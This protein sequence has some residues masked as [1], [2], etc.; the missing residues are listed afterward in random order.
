MERA[1]QLAWNRS[2]IE[3]RHLHLTS[4][5]AKNFQTFAGRV[6]FRPPLK[7]RHKQSI[8]V[9]SQGQSSLWAY[10][11]SGDLP[12]ILVRIE[13][14]AYIQFVVRLLTGHEYLRRMGC[15]FDLVILNE[16][17]SGYQ[18]DL[19]ESLRRAVEHGLERQ[20]GGPGGVFI[21]NGSQIPE[22]DKM[23]LLSAARL[24]L[25]ADGPSLRAQIKPAR[26]D[27]MP[28]A[29]AP[30]QTASAFPVSSVYQQH[31]LLFFNGWGGFSADGKEYEIILK[32]DNHLPAPWI[33]VM[34]N[35]C[36]G[37]LVSE[38][39]TGYTWWRNSREF[40]LTPGP[41]I[42]FSTIPGDVLPAG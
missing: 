39:G 40:K 28:A 29:L 31:E 5:E 3:L 16:S 37:C 33:N 15:S 23:L 22:E 13:D 7:K 1:F 19:R 20:S 35:P 34:A 9:N 17:A 24:V 11:V 8:M 30:K 41:M 2:Q 18:E 10:G 42:R 36:F 14:R 38:L 12:I 32:D 25:R 6:L 21:V 27:K 4:N 26:Q